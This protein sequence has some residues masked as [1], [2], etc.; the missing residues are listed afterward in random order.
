MTTY[1]E[2]MAICSL[3]DWTDHLNQ[4]RIQPG[5]LVQTMDKVSQHIQGTE[6]DDL[7]EVAWLALVAIESHESSFQDEVI[8]ATRLFN[9]ITTGR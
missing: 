3:I 8:E 2:R 9:L 6:S 5:Q 4:C 1:R 7:V